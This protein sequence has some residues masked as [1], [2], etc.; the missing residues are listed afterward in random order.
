MIEND[1]RKR[2]FKLERKD[3]RKMGLFFIIT[4]SVFLSPCS[5]FKKGQNVNN[6]PKTSY[7]AELEELILKEIDLE[8]SELEIDISSGKLVVKAPDLIENFIKK[9]IDKHEEIKQEEEEYNPNAIYYKVAKEDTFSSIA[10]KNNMT[11]LELKK[12]N[13][14]D[15]YLIEEG[16]KIIVSIIGEKEETNTVSSFEEDISKYGKFTIDGMTLKDYNDYLTQ[17]WNQVITEGE[18]VDMEIDLTKSYNYKDIENV[19]FNLAKY[20]GVNLYTIGKSVEGRNIYAINIDF[21]NDIKIINGQMAVSENISSKKI[22]LTT[23]QIHGRESAGCDFIL[24]QLNDLLRQ[25]Q[26]DSYIKALLANTIFCSVPLVNPDVREAIINGTSAHSIDG[27]PQKTNVNDVDLNRNFPSVNAGQLAVGATKN[28]KFSDKPNTF[29]GGYTLG[30]EPETRA[31]MKWLDELVPY[32]HSI[33]DYHQQGGG[34]YPNKGW[35]SKENRERYKQYAKQINALLSDRGVIT[36]SIFGEP[37]SGADGVGGSLT[38]YANSVA[39]GMKFSTKY[40]R[41]VFV[42]KNKEEIP[43]VVYYDLDRIKEEHVQTNPLFVTGTLEI[44]RTREAYGNSKRARELRAKEYK[45]QNFA[46]LLQYRAELALG[47]KRLEQI[48]N[49]ILT[50]ASKF[51]SR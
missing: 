23:G 20:D 13:N 16:Q 27:Y 8:T 33:L 45:N 5:P 39:M 49:N 50:E 42:N 22:I 3:V 12:L 44:G 10:T 34:I 6:N 30:S 21:E 2:K 1:N 48:K 4:S 40:G 41:M 9:E 18:P 47:S 17:E 38:D 15:N 32:S 11:A 19:L 24:K 25:S 7:S 31:V 43:L 29:F 26:T 28:V 51:V 37:Y 36:Y 14:L 35:D 46:Q